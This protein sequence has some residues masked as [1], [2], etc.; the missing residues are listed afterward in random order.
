MGREAY[1]KFFKPLLIGKFAEQYDQVPMSFMWA[2]IVKRSLKLGTYVGG[3]QAFL[4]ELAAQLRAKGVTIRLN[5]RVDGIRPLDAGLSLSVDGEQVAFDRVLSTTSPRLLL[6]MADGLA[7]TDYGKQVAALKSIGGLMR[8]LR[9]EAAADARRHLLAEPAGDNGG[10]VE[11]GFSLPGAGRAYQLPL[12]R[13]LWRRPHHLL[14][15]LRQAEPR[16]LSAERGGAGRA[17]H[18][19]AEKGESGFP[20]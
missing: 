11:V 15:R 18:A 10:Q 2:R 4:D 17:L 14:R 20:A 1:E 13:T 19:G 8:R 5:T 9:L 16:V 6:Q 7:D 12:A 3:F